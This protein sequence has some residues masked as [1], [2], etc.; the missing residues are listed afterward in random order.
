MTIWHTICKADDSWPYPFGHVESAVHQNLVNH[1]GIACA[2]NQG[3]DLHVLAVGG[4]GT[5]WHTIRFA[6]GSWQQ[7]FGG[8]GGAVH[9]NIGLIGRIA[10]ATNQ[11]GDL[12]VLVV[13]GLSRLW[14]TIRFADGSWQQFFGDIG[15]ALHQSIGL[16]GGIACATNQGGDLHVLATDLGGK[17]WHT[18]RLANGSW[19]NPFQDVLGVINKDRNIGKTVHSFACATNQGGDLHVLALLSGGSWSGDTLW[20]TLRKANGSWPYEYD[21]ERTANQSIK[22]NQSIKNIKETRCATN[23]G[24]DLHVLVTN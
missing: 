8:V 13:D 22:D 23:R 4:G 17:L 2:T 16:I 10:C 7:G 11:G 18:I 15:G 5:L 9:Q 24:G 12:H 19:P 21:V 3:G 1:Q 6:D 14:H 20:H